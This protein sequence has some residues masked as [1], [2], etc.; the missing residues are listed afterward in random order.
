MTSSPWRSDF[1][2]HSWARGVRL[3]TLMARG[4]QWLC[5]FAHGSFP[6]LCFPLRLMGAN[7]KQLAIFAPVRH[8]DDLTCSERGASDQ[9][10]SSKRDR[11]YPNSNS[12]KSMLLHT[13]YL[14]APFKNV[15][16]IHRNT[17]RNIKHYKCIQFNLV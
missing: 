17:T 10:R 4:S 6:L 3:T 7:L 8:F 14:R 16:Q 13:V 5:N 15:S 12:R 1:R 11:D 2:G 9:E